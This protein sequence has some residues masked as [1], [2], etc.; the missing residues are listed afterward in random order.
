MD[1]YH[2]P[3][4]G[5]RIEGVGG[6]FK[7]ILTVL[8]SRSGL[9]MFLEVIRCILTEYRPIISILDPFQAKFAI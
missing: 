5:V 4:R 2:R 7:A 3:P 9:K 6:I 8:G 1:V